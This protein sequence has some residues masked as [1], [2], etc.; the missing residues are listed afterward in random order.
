MIAFLFWVDTHIDLY[1]GIES[2]EH[3]FSSRYGYRTVLGYAYALRT[4]SHHEITGITFRQFLVHGNDNGIEFVLTTNQSQ[5]VFGK[6]H[7]VEVDICNKHNLCIAG[8][9]W[10]THIQ[11]TCCSNRRIVGRHVLHRPILSV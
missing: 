9:S 8:Y 6:I 2:S 1:L 4:A 3:D 11:S 7:E 10:H 5:T